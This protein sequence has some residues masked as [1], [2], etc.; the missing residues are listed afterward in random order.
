MPVTSLGEILLF[1]GTAD[2]LLNV[3]R[4]DDKEPNV[5]PVEADDPGMLAAIRKARE[6]FP[7]FLQ[8]VEADSRRII[9]ALSFA[10]VKAY[11]ADVGSPDEGEHMW[12]TDVEFDGHTIT[13]TLC[14]TPEHVQCVREGQQVN[15]PSDH[16][17][18]WLYVLV[19]E[20]HGGFTLRLLRSR[21]SDAERQAHDSQYPFSFAEA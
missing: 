21:M 7:D 14:D 8:A 1:R 12:V 20:A 4:K 17:S 3:M 13:G 15:F 9:P 11:F 18:D 5:S 16:L 10:L 2:T 6:T 19:D